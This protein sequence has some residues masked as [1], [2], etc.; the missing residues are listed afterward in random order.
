MSDRAIDLNKKLTG[1]NNRK[2]ELGEKCLPHISLC[3]ALVDEK[4]ISQISKILNDISL[5]YETLR[6]T[7]DKVKVLSPVE[8]ET[9]SMFDI[10]NTASIK[11][12]QQ[13]IMTKLWPYLTYEDIKTDDFVDPSEVEDISLYWVRGYAEKYNNPGAFHP[14]LSIG[15]GSV[16]NIDRPIEFTAPTIA[17][18]QL[19]NYCT[20]RKVISSYDLK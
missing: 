2:I 9:F 3:M 19:G 1:N 17:L 13:T 5:Q 6:L 18:C 12:L 20:C 10:S 16:A 8:G 11:S 7:A 15:V 14:H 4:D